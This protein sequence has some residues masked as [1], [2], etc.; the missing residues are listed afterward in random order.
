MIS[1]SLTLTK[2]LTIFVGLL[3][4]ATIG[5]IVGGGIWLVGR[6]LDQRALDRLDDARQHAVL[7]LQLEQTRLESNVT[8]MANNPTLPPL[9]QSTDT[10][11]LTTTL[12]DWRSIAALD[13]LF[14]ANP[15]GEILAGTAPTADTYR[16]EFTQPIGALGTLTGVIRLDDELALQMAAS[17]ETTYRFIGWDH[18]MPANL[19]PERIDDPPRYRAII[20]LAN[21]VSVAVLIDAPRSDFSSLTL[22]VLGSILALSLLAASTALASGLFARSRVRPIWQLTER[23]RRMGAGDL[24]TPITVRTKTLEAHTLARILEETRIRLQQ[25]VKALSESRQWSESLIQSV[26]EGIITCDAEGTVIFFSAGATRITGWAAQVAQ[27]QKLADLL[28]VGEGQGR[29][30][31]YIPADGGRRSVVIRRQDGNPITLAVTRS[32][33]IKAGQVTIVIHD[34]TEEA[35]RHKA[36]TYFLATMSHEFRTP[37][38]GMRASVELLLE[39]LR[40]LSM[41]ETRQLLHSIRLGLSTLQQLIDNLLEGSKLEADHFVLKRRATEFDSLLGA[42]IRLVEPLIVRRGQRLALEEPLQLPE[43]WVDPPRII[44]ALVNLLSNASKYSPND[45]AI[46]IIVIQQS[47]Q[48]R[49]SVADRGHGVAP[50]KQRSIF[51]PFVRLESELASEHGSGLGLSVVKAII[52]AHQGQVGVETRA[53]GGSIFWFTLPLKNEIGDGLRTQIGADRR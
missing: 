2:Q 12:A 35:Q 46:D 26:V 20:P 10:Q 42:A 19:Q 21:A 33:P 23:A 16:L 52:E 41:E 24:E 9:L 14:V 48:L 53:G 3:I 4:L 29:F 5:L 39:N 1:F 28:L 17:D 51:L 8:L 31:D 18:S 34:I 40:Y 49:V 45:S 7:F 43:L 11:P 44:Q 47:G 32:Q 15:Q 27:G 50:E 37:L 30:T 13:Y 25:N 38:S 36:Q 6:E 22:P